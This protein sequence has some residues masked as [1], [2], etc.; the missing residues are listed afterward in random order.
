M[1]TIYS[2]NFYHLSLR[3]LKVFL[4]IADN[5]NHSDRQFL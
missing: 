5:F 3:M 4:A 2:R 1:E